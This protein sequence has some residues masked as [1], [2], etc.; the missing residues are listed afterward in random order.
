[1]KEGWGAKGEDDELGGTAGAV[2]ACHRRM[3]DAMLCGRIQ[4]P[5]KTANA[6]A[7]ANAVRVR[8]RWPF[9]L[10]AVPDHTTLHRPF[11]DGMH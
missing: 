7:R 11:K 2:N 1:M 10:G 5:A 6:F 4:R 3:D 9:L 8:T